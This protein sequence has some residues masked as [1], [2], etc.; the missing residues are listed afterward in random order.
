[1]PA[2]QSISPFHSIQKR[3]VNP[4]LKETAYRAMT[5]LTANDLWN[6][7]SDLKAALGTSGPR[8]SMGI[9]HGVFYFLTKQQSSTRSEVTASSLSNY[10]DVAHERP[11]GTAAVQA[12]V[13]ER[14]KHWSQMDRVFEREATRKSWTRCRTIVFRS[15]REMSVA[16]VLAYAHKSLQGGTRKSKIWEQFKYQERCWLYT[17]SRATPSRQSRAERC[18]GHHRWIAH[19][20]HQKAVDIPEPRLKLNPR[21]KNEVLDSTVQVF[22]KKP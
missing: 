21:H 22:C 10:I 16:P 12:A 9:V 15:V 8:E 3:S 13:K 5:Q 19:A 11:C 6:T 18:D 17:C 4:Y 14:A 2:L 1:M 7:T 20:Y